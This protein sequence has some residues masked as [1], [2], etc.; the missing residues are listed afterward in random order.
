MK[1]RLTA[2]FALAAVVAAPTIATAAPLIYPDIPAK[3]SMDDH[4]AVVTPLTTTAAAAHQMA[5]VVPAS[6]IGPG[7]R[8]IYPDIPAKVSMDDHMAV[9]TPLTTTATAAHKTAAIVPTNNDPSQAL[10]AADHTYLT[11]L[12][13][14]VLSH[15]GNFTSV[16]KKFCQV[17]TG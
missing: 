17:K 11:S 8:L 13:P 15:P 14:N 4:M 16:Y 5:A 3:V 7:G 6:L 12:C 9:V 2:L 10:F 1:H